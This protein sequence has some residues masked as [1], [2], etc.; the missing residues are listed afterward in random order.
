MGELVVPKIVVY[1]RADDARVIQATEGREIGQWV[2]TLVR[3]EIE[4]WHSRRR[5]ALDAQRMPR[6]WR[7][8]D[9]EGA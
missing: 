9:E 1:V 6:Q 2:R 4:H 5:S 3:E 8:F 7:R